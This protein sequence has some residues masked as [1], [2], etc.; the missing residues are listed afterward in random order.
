MAVNNAFV[1]GVC[2]ASAS[3]KST[4]CEELARLLPDS[5]HLSIDKFFK[6]ELPTIIS[7]LDGREYPDW[8]HPDSIDSDKARDYIENSLTGFRFILLD[9]AL[10]FSIES[11]RELCDYKIFVTA[12]IET[13]IYRRIRRNITLKKQTIEQIADYYLKTVRYREAEFAIPSCKYAD[14]MVDNENGFGDMLG[15]AANEILKREK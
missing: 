6:P 5:V 2:G 14:L 11:L 15:F 3:G 7:P 13:R 4:F 9:G 12:A 8:N 1:I 10:L